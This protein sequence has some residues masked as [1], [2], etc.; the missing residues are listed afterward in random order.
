MFMCMQ[1]QQEVKEVTKGWHLELGK[2][3]DGLSEELGLDDFSKAKLRDFI[4]E[5]AKE[6]YKMGNRSGIRWARSCPSPMRQGVDAA[7]V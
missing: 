5:K 3:V 1:D 4:F 7:S 6:Q 2:A